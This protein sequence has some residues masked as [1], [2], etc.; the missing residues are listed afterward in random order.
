VTA[1]PKFLDVFEQ[2]RPRL[3]GIGYRM[4]GD[5]HEAEDLVQE[6]YLRWHEA[7]HG[8][9][10]TPEGWLVT[11]MTRLAIDRLH[12]AETER[13]SYVGHWIPEPIATGIGAQDSGAPDLRVERESDLSIAFLMLLERLGAEER[14]AFLL[15]ELFDTPYEEIARIID[16]TPATARQ[17]VH[18]ARERVRDDRTRYAVPADAQERLLSRFLSALGDGDRDA[19]LALFDDDAS[20]VS[21][22]GGKSPAVRR[23]I[24]GPDRITRLLTGIERKWHGVTTHRIATLNG[25]PCILTLV[26]GRVFAVTAFAT[27]GDRIH[28]AYRVMNPDKLHFVGVPPLGEVGHAVRRGPESSGGNE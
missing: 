25:E 20:F 24:E 13:L 5:A 12:R 9:I 22:G 23:I 15:R 28:R 19:L 3:F 14:A 26:F 11:V 16:R 18:R 8:S 27:D 4:L 2:L 17:M 6:C 21:D 10:I 1:S 7:D